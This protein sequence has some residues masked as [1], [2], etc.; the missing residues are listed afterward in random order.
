LILQKISVILILKTIV[1]SLF[2]LKNNYKC[3][4]DFI[5]ILIKYNSYTI[6]YLNLRLCSIYYYTQ[7]LDNYSYKLIFS[8]INIIVNIIFLTTLQSTLLTYIIIKKN[9]LINS[10]ENIFYNFWWF[11]RELNELS[12]IY[13]K[14]KRDS[15]N[16]LLE[17]NNVYKPMLKEF[18][19]I[20]IYE[21][22][23]NFIYQSLTHIKLSV[24]I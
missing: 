16:L 23:Y 7:S 4:L 13:I 8:K 3:N 10:L 18:P 9:G 19:S 14:N 2:I 24:Q 12:G 20:G 11:E 22:Y 15:R 5:H 17:Y 6:L 21:L 1:Y